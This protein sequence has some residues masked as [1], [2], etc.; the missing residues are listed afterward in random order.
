MTFQSVPDTAEVIID[1]TLN[2]QKCV[3]TFYANKPGGYVQADLDE[4][5]DIVDAWVGAELRPLLSEN[6]TYVRT[7]VRGLNASIDSEAENNGNAGVGGVGATSLPNNVA[8]SV[9][10]R[11]AFTGRGARGRVFIGGIPST[12]LDFPNVV[13]DTFITAITAALNALSE[14]VSEVDFV[15]VIVHRVAAGV[16]LAEAVIFTVVEYVVVNNVIDSMRRRLP[17]RGV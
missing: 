6:W 5:A 10:R 12:A 17:G 3:N 9:K 15:E 14:N 1:A 4:L 8:L 16:P 7:V 11:S 2:G 13:G